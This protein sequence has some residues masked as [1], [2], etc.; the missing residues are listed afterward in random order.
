ML[1]FFMV[2][3]INNPNKNINSYGFLAQRLKHQTKSHQ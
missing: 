1:Y 3:P 2:N